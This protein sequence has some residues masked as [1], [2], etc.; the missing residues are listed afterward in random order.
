MYPQSTST[1]RIGTRSS[2]STGTRRKIFKDKPCLA[3]RPPSPNLST[4][5]LNFVASP[6]FLLH[7]SAI[8]RAVQ[9]AANVAT[10]SGVSGKNILQA[11]LLQY[12]PGPSI[13]RSRSNLRIASTNLQAH[14]DILPKDLRQ[15]YKGQH[16]E[17]V[18]V[19]SSLN[20]FH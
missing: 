6:S 14:K 12:L 9:D 4:V 15:R 18:L 17:Y 13:E 11:P 3:C 16:K 19:F 2:S 10:A 7:M 8:E 1:H 5:Q 20:C